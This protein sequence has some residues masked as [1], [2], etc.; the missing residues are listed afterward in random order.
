[1]GG[2]NCATSHNSS[3]INLTNDIATDKSSA[4]SVTFD[5]IYYDYRSPNFDITTAVLTAQKNSCYWLHLGVDVPEQ[6]K[7]LLSLGNNFTLVKTSNAFKGKD[8]LSKDGIFC[9]PRE[10][11]LR[12]TS[13]FPTLSVHW[14]GFQIDTIF[15]PLIAIYVVRSS[16]TSTQNEAITFDKVLYNIGQAWNVHSNRFSA[17]FDGVYY[18]SFGGGVTPKSHFQLDLKV[19]GAKLCTASNFMGTKIVKNGFDFISKSC[20]VKINQEDDIQLFNAGPYSVYSD[21]IYQQLSLVGFY[22]SPIRNKQVSHDHLKYCMRRY[23]SNIGLMWF[24]EPFRQTKSK[25]VYRKFIF[26]KAIT[27]TQ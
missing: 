11:H 22:Y 4:F 10:S 25:N 8:T 23:D 1:M 19:N 20:M 2:N 14:T 15:D 9:F 3:S 17:P 16:S 12:V 5:S 21:P 7:V 24:Y 26:E 27:F 6:G 13:R 18:F